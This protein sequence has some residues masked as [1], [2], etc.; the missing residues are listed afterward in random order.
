MNRRAFSGRSLLGALAA[1]FAGN[2]SQGPKPPYPP[3]ISPGIL[4]GG[5]PLSPAQVLYETQRKSILSKVM[6][7][8]APP[9]PKSFVDYI[10]ERRGRQNAAQGAMNRAEQRHIPHNIRALRSVSAQHKALMAEAYND[11]RYHGDPNREMYKTWGFHKL[12]DNIPRPSTQDELVAHDWQAMWE[13]EK[14]AEY[15]F[16][17]LR[18]PDNPGG[19][20]VAAEG[21]RY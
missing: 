10:L 4:G 12:F 6:A 21:R 3:T 17:D 7:F 18:V 15:G 8:I 11:R 1:P 2:I 20:D 9:V 14:R 5:N 13:A 16:N 19:G